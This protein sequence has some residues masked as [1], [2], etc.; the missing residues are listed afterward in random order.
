MTNYTSMKKQS[1]STIS[2]EAQRN[3]SGGFNFPHHHWMILLYITK[4]KPYEII[5]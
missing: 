3:F 1:L 2:K 4:E 5:D